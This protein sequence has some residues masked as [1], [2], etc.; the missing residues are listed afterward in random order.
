MYPLY[1]WCHR[2]VIMSQIS[3][4][5]SAAFPVILLH[6]IN[7]SV[8]FIKKANNRLKQTFYNKS[9]GLIGTS[10]S[11]I[12]HCWFSKYYKKMC[13]QENI[14]TSEK[15]RGFLPISTQLIIDRVYLH[16]WLNPRSGSTFLYPPFCGSQNVHQ[17]INSQWRNSKAA[18]WRRHFEEIYAMICLMAIRNV[19]LF[20]EAP[21]H[22]NGPL[23]G[24]T[25]FLRFRIETLRGIRFCL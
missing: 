8:Y 13:K 5:S 10:I 25:N 19:F 18:I 1:W 23:G 7:I 4:S 15:G 2:Y 9:G 24:I 21:K 20:K 17:E 12:T 14:W 3:W 11:Q 6:N 22:G 16:D